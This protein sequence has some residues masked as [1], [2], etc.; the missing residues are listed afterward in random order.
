MH[1]K[2]LHTYVEKQLKPVIYE[3]K[4]SGAMPKEFFDP[5]LLSFTYISRNIMQEYNKE[6]DKRDIE[7]IRYKLAS[8]NPRNEVNR[9]DRK[10]EEILQKLNQ[11]E[12]SKYHEHIDLGS[13]E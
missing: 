8:A 3:L 10:E 5:R 13:K 11:N 1:N 2:A 4:S 6:R 9:A 7:P 12:L